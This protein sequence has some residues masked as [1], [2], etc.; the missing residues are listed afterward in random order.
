MLPSPCIINKSWWYFVVLLI[1]R[2]LQWQDTTLV[3]L[4]KT[5]ALALFRLFLLICISKV[6]ADD[7]LIKG[8]N[9]D[10]FFGNYVQHQNS[11]LSGKPLKTSNV[12]TVFDCLSDCSSN[13]QC[14][15]TNVN[16]TRDGKGLFECVLLDFDKYQSQA[17]FSVV[18]GVDHYTLP[19]SKS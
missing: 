1:K 19:V 18:K 7:A 9:S 17:N 6:F 12:T 5:M 14:V 3:L 13:T 4:I 16:T 10:L 15:S 2:F 11:L 8:R